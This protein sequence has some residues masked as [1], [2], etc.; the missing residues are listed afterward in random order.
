MPENNLTDTQAAQSE[1]H[2]VRSVIITDRKFA[3]EYFGSI[4]DLLA[5]LS[6]RKVE[7][8]LVL[9]P[10][11]GIDP[12]LWPQTNIVEHPFLRLPLLWKRNYRDLTE[13]LDKF[14][15]TVVHC[16]GPKK[17]ALARTVSRY[18][19]IPAVVSLNSATLPRAAVSKIRTAFKAVIV[20]SES[21]AGQIRKKHSRISH[22][23]K[24]IR[25]GVFVDRDC[26]CFSQNGR[27][28]S[29]ITVADMDRFQDFEPLLSA[30]RHLAVDGYEFLAVLMGRGRAEKKIKEFI[31]GVGLTQTVNMAEQTRPLQAILRGADIYIHLNPVNGFSQILIEAA[32]A[33]LAVT[34]DKSDM[35]KLL[36]TGKTAM[37]FDPSD[38]LSIYAAIQKLL[39]RRELARDIA[40]GLQSYIRDNHGLSNMTEELVKIYSADKSAL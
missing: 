23:V 38:E 31:T 9:E 20:P 6:E 30:I 3:Y 13:R 2:D 11:T 24:R 7:T 34:A 8:I 33:G 40:R 32:S 28:P 10:E 29:L 26:A 5:G 17:I 16:L 18:F 35:G 25:F 14:R 4:R 36:S 12:L 15:P 19:K 21:I 22:L 27:I 1:A 39:D 37:F